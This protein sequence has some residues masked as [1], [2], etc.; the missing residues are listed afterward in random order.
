MPVSELYYKWYGKDWLC[1]SGIDCVVLFVCFCVLISALFFTSQFRSPMPLLLLFYVLYPLHS[2]TSPRQ[3]LNLRI[4]KQAC[5]TDREV[6]DFLAT[7]PQDPLRCVVKPVQSAGTDDGTYQHT[8]P[9]FYWPYI[10]EPLLIL[11]SG[12]IQYFCAWVWKKQWQ[13]LHG[14]WAKEMD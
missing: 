10:R 1:S 5:T 3:H 12:W 7:L 13:P 11:T 9:Y 4:T 14:F 2:L 6:L 8:Y